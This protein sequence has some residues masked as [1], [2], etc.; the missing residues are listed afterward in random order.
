MIKRIDTEGWRRGSDIVGRGPRESGGKD[1]GKK[2]SANHEE[3]GANRVDGTG[4]I[5]R[6]TRITHIR[7]AEAVWLDLHQDFQHFIRRRDD[8][9]VGLERSIVGEH[10]D[11]FLVQIDPSN[12][13]V[14]SGQHGMQV[15]SALRDAAL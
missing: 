5:E 4:A 2:S 1:N 6:D 11:R 13:E 15:V 9:R 7:P 12:A 3:P 14:L 10:L 8:T